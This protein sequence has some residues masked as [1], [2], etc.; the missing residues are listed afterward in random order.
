[1]TD[2]DHEHQTVLERK[3]LSARQVH[4]AL[5]LEG[6]EE[7]ERTTPGLLR[8]S[9]RRERGSSRAHGG[10]RGRPRQRLS[11]SCGADASAVISTTVPSLQLY[12]ASDRLF[13]ACAS[14]GSRLSSMTRA[15]PSKRRPLTRTWT[16]IRRGYSKSFGI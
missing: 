14:S 11:A 9:R 13:T 15:D 16:A 7:L 10:R 4:A 3:E 2:S 5:R 8:K 6:E 1:M 12:F